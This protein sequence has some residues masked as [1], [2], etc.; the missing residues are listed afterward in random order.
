MGSTRLPGKILS[1]IN[2]VPLLQHLIRRTSKSKKITKIV[3]ATTTSAEDD[4]TEHFCRENQLECF[5]GSNE[6]VLD[7]YYQTAKQ[8]PE[9]D[10]VVRLTGDCPLIDPEVIDQVVELFEKG[11]YDYVSNVN[12]PTFPDGLDVEVFRRSALEEAWRDSELTSEREHVT[13]F[14]RQGEKFKKGNLSGQEDL[15][16]YRFTVDQLEDLAVVKFLIEN[17]DENSNYR[18]H[19]ELINRHPDIKKLNLTAKRNEG[20]AKSLKNDKK[21]KKNGK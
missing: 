9:Y 15:S 16:S 17:S 19:I 3:V 12:P 13:L 5:R 18:N 21:I 10:T 8:Y 20:L 7:R 4:A 2:G 11:D 1:E 14:I 6:D